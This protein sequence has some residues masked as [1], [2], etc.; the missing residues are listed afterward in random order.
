MRKKNIFIAVVDFILAGL[1]LGLGIVMIPEVT[2]VGNIILLI[3]IGALLLVYVYYY[4]LVKVAKKSSG[5]I[6]ILTLIEMIVLTIIAVTC[7]L[8]EILNKT[9][10]GE[11]MKSLGLAFWIR[12]V[13]ESFRAYYYK[14]NTTKYPVYKVILN[15]ILITLG[16]WFFISNIISNL[17][18]VWSLAVI[19]VIA[20]IAMIILGIL[21]IKK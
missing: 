1:L 20:S 18:L 12:G 13:V 6:L 17:I 11:G 8:S 4:L 10:I 5:I 7:I 21:K 19:F 3:V 9:I 16:T 14:G 2:D 15:V